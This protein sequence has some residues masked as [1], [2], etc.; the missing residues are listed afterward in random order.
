MARPLLSIVPLMLGT[1]AAAPPLP[2]TRVTGNVSTEHHTRR[3][4]PLT[5]S[6]RVT[7]N[8][9]GRG[10]KSAPVCTLT[11]DDGTSFS[12]NAHER[13]EMGCTAT[14]MWVDIADKRVCELADRYGQS[15]LQVPAQLATDVPQS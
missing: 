1:A 5:N 13:E 7:G 3:E 6:C 10:G 4:A 9:V 2:A 11:A 14:G 12:L 15:P 8:I